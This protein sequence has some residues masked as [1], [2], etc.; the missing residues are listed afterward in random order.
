MLPLATKVSAAQ[1]ATDL[2]ENVA[3][4]KGNAS[5]IRTVNPADEDWTDLEPIGRAIGDAHTVMLG[6]GSHGDG[7][8]FVFKSGLIRFLHQQHGFNVIVWEA[9]FYEAYAVGGDARRDPQELT[10]R[11]AGMFSAGEQSTPSPLSAA[12]SSAATAEKNGREALEHYTELKTVWV[13]LG[14]R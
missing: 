4:L 12:A 3:W 13:N 14:K 6:E 10:F 9:P 5:P 7:T 8:T 11:R 2:R 1:V